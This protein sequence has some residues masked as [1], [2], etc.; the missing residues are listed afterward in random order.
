M[1]SPRTRPSVRS[2]SGR[3]ACRE[4]ASGRQQRGS[5]GPLLTPGAEVGSSNHRSN[6]AVSSQAASRSKPRIFEGRRSVILFG[7]QFS[8]RSAGRPMPAS[9]R[10]ALMSAGRSSGAAFMGGMRPQMRWLSG[11]Q[12]CDSF[13]PPQHCSFYWSYRPARPKVRL[14]EPP[15]LEQLMR[16]QLVLSSC[17][18]ARATT[19]KGQNASCRP[20]GQRLLSRLP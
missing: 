18:I 15:G 10:P 16:Q 8:W 2:R 19:V 5:R 20:F 12:K 17:P 7:T 4:E 9:A 6:F 14:L 13:G 3:T 1:A 11:I